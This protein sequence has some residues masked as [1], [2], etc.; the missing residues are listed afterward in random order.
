MDVWKFI[1]KGIKVMTPTIQINSRSAI[2]QKLIKSQKQCN[3]T[4]L[5]WTLA[6]FHVQNYILLYFLYHF[7]KEVGNFES[8]CCFCFKTTFSCK[9][10]ISQIS[11]YQ[12]L[13]V[14]YLVN[15][16]VFQLVCQS[17]DVSRNH[18]LIFSSFFP[19]VKLST[20]Y[21]NSTIHPIFEKR[22]ISRLGD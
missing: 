22:L 13:G 6:S 12:S 2:P 14:I 1:A 16:P 3:E 4:L 19:K 21:T 10:S 20:G 17:L 15:W 5:N 18:S 7:C 8:I 9:F 11:H